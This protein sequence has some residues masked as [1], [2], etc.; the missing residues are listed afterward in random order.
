MK[1]LRQSWKRVHRVVA[2]L[3]LALLMAALCP[4]Q[5]APARK[6]HTFHGRVEAV[7]SDGLTVNGEKVE[8]WMDAMTMRYKV[9][10]PRVLKKVK[11]GDE[12][13]ATVYE[14]DL[15]LHKVQVAAKSGK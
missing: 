5:A 12:I 11:V 1:R 8:G 3:G 13:T 14:G 6:S 2:I 10:D 15:L 9:D 7:S 4:G